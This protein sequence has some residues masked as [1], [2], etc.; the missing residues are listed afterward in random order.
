MTDNSNP[1]LPFSFYKGGPFEYLLKEP[2]AQELWEYLSNKSN[3]AL[4][5]EA[6][7]NGKPPLWPL[8]EYVEANFGE[9]IT[10]ELFP[11]DDVEIMVNNM[12][13]QIMEYSGYEHAACGMLRHARYIKLSGVYNKKS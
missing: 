3:I 6:A 7:N 4:M 1:D 12:I 10:S 13:K 2:F 9:F 5:V 8:L 11:G